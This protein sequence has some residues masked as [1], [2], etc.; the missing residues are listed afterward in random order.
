MPEI[1]IIVPVYKS[2]QYL[3]KC[4]ESILAQTFTDFELILVDDGSP[5][6]S[7]KLC[8]VYAQKDMRIRVIHQQNAGVS[9]ARNAGLMCATGKYIMFCDSDDWVAPEWCQCL[10]NAMKVPNVVIAMCGYREWK[11]DIVT[12]TC[13]LSKTDS[14]MKLSELFAKPLPGAPWNKIYNRER[15]VEYNITFPDGISYG[16]DLRFLLTYLETYNGDNAVYLSSSI[17][18]NYRIVDESLSHKCIKDYWRLEKDVIKLRLKVASAHNTDFEKCRE[19]LYC[20]YYRLFCC[21]I[22]H[23]FSPKNDLPYSKKYKEL[24]EIIRS[25]EI[26]NMQ[27][28]KLFKEFPLWYQMILKK[29]ITPLLFAYHIWR[30]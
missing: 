3:P 22:K 23:L 30:R 19:E 24:N 4:I 26:E 27:K 29:R 9:A 11:G 18:N 28:S 15:I 5:D 2:E 13:N 20:Y 17:L 25:E 8:D 14:T 7:G 12:Q 6:E 10:Y 16:E 1:S 21:S